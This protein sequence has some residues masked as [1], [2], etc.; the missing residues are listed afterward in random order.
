[1]DPETQRARA[2][3]ICLGF[4]ET[5]ELIQ[6]P[7]HSA[8]LVNGQKFCCFLN[9][10]HGDGVVGLT[11]KTLPGVQAALI[12]LDRERFYLPAYVARNGWIGMRLDIEP[13]DWA[14][15]EQLL[16]EA[17]SAAAPKRLLKQLEMRGAPR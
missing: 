7:A 8:F 16:G 2:R 12:D 9:N 14:Q 10:H 5:D 11:C 15:A 13:V 4:P 3:E 6:N 1:M 17:Y